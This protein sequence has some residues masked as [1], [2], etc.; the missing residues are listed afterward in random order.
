MP[1]GDAAIYAILFRLSRLVKLEEKRRM[2]VE[3]CTT[4]GDKQRNSIER[5]IGEV[6]TLDNRVFA[7]KPYP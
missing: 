6:E 5:G 2:D 3:R 1:Q 7:I 4:K